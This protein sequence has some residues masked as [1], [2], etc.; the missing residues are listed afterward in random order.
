MRYVGVLY[1][2]RSPETLFHA[3][4]SLFRRRPDLGDKVMVEFVGLTPPEM[5][6]T[7]AA[8]TLPEGTIS[9]V[10]SVS[11]VES[12]A[13]MYGADILLLIEANISKNLFLPSKLSDYM[14]ARTPMVGLVPPGASEDAFRELDCWYAR[15]ND[16]DRISC[17]IEGAVDHVQNRKDARW[18]NDDYRETFSGTQVASRFSN[19]IAGL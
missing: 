2:R 19:I 12:L 4:A 8:L 5:L 10:G 6:Q 7:P 15:P 14:G 16:I 17:A 11:F 9:T 1:G 3:L 18:C 13:L